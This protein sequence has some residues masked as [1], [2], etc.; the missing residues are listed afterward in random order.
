[1]KKITALCAMTTGQYFERLRETSGEA[2]A[3][4]NDHGQCES[5]GIVV[6]ALVV[7]VIPLLL[8]I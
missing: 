8:N 7:M 6:L 1:M 2:H 3:H 5:W 4:Q